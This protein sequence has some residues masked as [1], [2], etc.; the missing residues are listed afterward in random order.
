MN[1]YNHVLIC[2]MNT[3]ANMDDTGRIFVQ[4]RV[5]GAYTRTRSFIPVIVI[6]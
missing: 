2:M 5:A 4:K 6:A 1:I 3:R